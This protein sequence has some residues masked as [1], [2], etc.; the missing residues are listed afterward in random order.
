MNQMKSHEKQSRQKIP[1]ACNQN[2]QPFALG[3]ITELASTS[4]TS[5]LSIARTK[6][7]SPPAGILPTVRATVMMK[8]WLHNLF[9]GFHSKQVRPASPK[10]SDV[11]THE[12]V[13]SNKNSGLSADI[14]PGTSTR[15]M[16][17]RK[18]TMALAINVRPNQ[19]RCL[20]IIPCMAA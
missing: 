15:W 5:P 7:D 9:L 10:I 20:L 8:M 4:V 12:V 6:M 2:V 16:D 18:A 3:V 19:N 1:G 14:G 11:T 17:D 13:D